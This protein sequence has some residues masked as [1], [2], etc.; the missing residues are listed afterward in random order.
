MPNVEK[1]PRAL[2]STP[3]IY[4]RFFRSRRASLLK[5]D[6]NTQLKSLAPL[7]F[8]LFVIFFGSFDSD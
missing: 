7:G 4:A 8:K 5:K 3:F 6:P 1:G 2:L